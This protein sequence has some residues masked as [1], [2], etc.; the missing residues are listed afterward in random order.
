MVG[1]FHSNERE[2]RFAGLHVTEPFATTSDQVTDFCP[3][4]GTDFPTGT[5]EAAPTGT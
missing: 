3:S 4:S 1:L 2:I 5:A